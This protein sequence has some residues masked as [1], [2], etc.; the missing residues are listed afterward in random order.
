MVIVNAL[1]NPVSNEQAHLLKG[2]HLDRIT[3]SHRD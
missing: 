2:N 3:E 1:I